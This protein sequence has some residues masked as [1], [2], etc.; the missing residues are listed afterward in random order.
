MRKAYKIGRTEYGNK[1]IKGPERRVIY[2][3]GI[4]HGTFEKGVDMDLS[5]WAGNR[6]PKAYKADTSTECCFKY[7][8]KNGPQGYAYSANNHLDVDGLLSI[9]V[10]HD[11][12]HALL[13]KDLLIAMAEAGDF[14]KWVS[15]SAMLRT[16]TLIAY[17]EALKEQGLRIRYE[18]AIDFLYTLLQAQYAPP[19]IAHQQQDI[20]SQQKKWIE[21]GLITRTL[22]HDHLVA[23]EVPLEQ[24]GLSLSQDIPP[25][26]ATLTSPHSLHGWVLNIQDFERLKL[27][28]YTSARAIS[29]ELWV[30]SYAWADTL[31]LWRPPFLKLLSDGLKVDGQGLLHYLQRYA[32]HW[33]QKIIKAVPQVYPSLQLVG[34]AN[35]RPF[36]V[37]L[38]AQE[39]I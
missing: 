23:Y 32:L 37:V 34:R 18:M 3:D 25:F 39:K 31:T 19:V 13:H 35:P 2:V 24:E 6:T 8:E 15:E 14:N 11:P 36:P 21:E 29:Y 38:R 22:L 28:I 26:N 9:F 16:H 4:D 7:L 12:C 30:P 33:G 1:K 17:M 27:V 5:H 20:L 10:M